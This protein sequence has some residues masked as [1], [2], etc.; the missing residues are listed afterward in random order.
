MCGLSRRVNIYNIV[1]GK[2]LRNYRCSSDDTTASDPVRIIVDSAGLYSFTLSTDC[3]IRMYDFFSGE[4]VASAVVP[5]F[6]VTRI[7]IVPS[8]NML[9]A[10]S[11]DGLLYVYEFSQEVAMSMRQTAVPSRPSTSAPGLPPDPRISG[12]VPSTAPPSM[13]TIPDWA[14]T[15]V[16][17][18]PK[19]KTNMM[20]VHDEDGQR[21]VDQDEVSEEEQPVNESANNLN[22]NDREVRAMDDIKLEEETKDHETTGTSS[23]VAQP[24]NV[25]ESFSDDIKD[26]SMPAEHSDASIN[27]QSQQI[28]MSSIQCSSVKKNVHTPHADAAIQTEVKVFSDECIGSAPS[29]STDK[30]CQHELVRVTNS[31]SCQCSVERADA[32]VNVSPS[33]DDDSGMCVM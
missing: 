20:N 1:N 9:I 27:E 14:R 24:E 11:S 21:E 30:A 12:R 18:E 23:V 10:S 3:R 6:C 33:M 7:C 19:S 2:L 16:M 29:M 8:C 26:E 4:M 28:P 15:R 17:T 31:I 25:N 32:G 13:D 22:L 5:C